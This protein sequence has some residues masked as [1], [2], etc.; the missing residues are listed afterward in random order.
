M[1][2]ENPDI[3]WE[4][5]FNNFEKTYLL[6]ENSLKIKSP[7]KTEKAGIIQFYEMSFE[8]SWNLLKDYLEEEGYN[9][10]SPRAAIKQ[11]FSSGIIKDG[12]LWIEALEDRNLMSH[13]YDEEIANNVIESINTK[14]YPALRELFNFM[15]DESSK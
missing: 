1:A 9:L 12:H 5:R 8:L 3:R 4:H 11:A 6:L 10:K 14:Y 13:T 7:N 2:L 15:K